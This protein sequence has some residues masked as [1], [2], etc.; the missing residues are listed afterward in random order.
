M[1]VLLS[2]EHFMFRFLAFFFFSPPRLLSDA[3]CA[4][5]AHVEGKYCCC[6]ECVA[7]VLP[8]F[9]SLDEVNMVVVTV[10]LSTAT[11][12]LR[13]FFFFVT[14]HTPLPPRTF[15]NEDEEFGPLC[16]GARHSPDVMVC[17]LCHVLVGSVGVVSLPSHLWFTGGVGGGWEDLSAVSQFRCW[18]QKSRAP[19][20]VRGGR[21]RDGLR[22]MGGRKRKGLKITWNVSG[23]IQGIIQPTE[24][25]FHLSFFPP[26]RYLLWTDLTREDD[27]GWKLS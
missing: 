1:V 13:L 5:S 6:T 8:L 3:T 18:T 21:R 15:V 10:Q 20:D 26:A 16:F 24:G 11:L 14:F 4:V 22:E 2:R 19:K 27:A 17:N 23:H 12:P 9:L 7:G 25:R